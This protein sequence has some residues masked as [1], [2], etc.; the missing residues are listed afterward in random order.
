MFSFRPCSPILRATNPHPQKLDE[1]KEHGCPPIRLMGN[2]SVLSQR[3]ALGAWG[4]AAGTEDQPSN[5]G[6][7]KTNH[8]GNMFEGVLHGFLSES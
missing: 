4:L 5:G 8:Q 6:D 2:G 3:L 1:K 7:G